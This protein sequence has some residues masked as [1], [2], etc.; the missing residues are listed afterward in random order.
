MSSDDASA[1]AT[2]TDELVALART[3][4]GAALDAVPDGDVLTTLGRTLASEAPSSLRFER[5]ADDLLE[6]G[7]VIG[8]GGMGL[9]RAARQL[10]VGREV[11]VK[12]LRPEQQS[13]VAEAML[14]R[15]AWLTASL[16]HPNVVPVHDVVVDR[17][18][19][20]LI[21]LKRVKGTSW[22]EVLGDGA[23]VKEKFGSDDLLAF[24][25]DVLMQICRAAHFAHASGIVHRDI[26]PS[27]VMLGAYGEVYLLDWGIATRFDAPSA[28]PAIAG[29][30]AYMAPEMLERG[31]RL[32]PRTDVYL[33]GAVLHEI[34]T[35]RAPHHKDTRD[36]II[37]SIL[38]SRPELPEDTPE[39]IARICARALARDPLDRYATA[40]E[41]RLE[42]SH[43]LKNRHSMRLLEE[44]LARL[45]DLTW[46][47]QTRSP[48]QVPKGRLFELFGQCRFGLQQA[49]AS[50]EHNERARR[51]QIDLLDHM[52]RHLLAIEDPG[53]AGALLAEH[54]EP[55]PELAAQVEEG[56]EA[57]RK[58]EEELERLRRDIDPGVGR[59]TRRAAMV[60]MGALWTCAPLLANVVDPTKAPLVINYVSPVVLLLIALGVW[61]YARDKLSQTAINRRF[62]VAMLVGFC[63]HMVHLLV[64]ALADLPHKT[65]LAMGMVSFGAILAILAHTAEKR[66]W[67]LVPVYWLGALV[68]AQDLSTSAYV[69]AGCNLLLTSYMFAIWSPR[70]ER[71]S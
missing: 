31:G 24:N 4:V 62:L 17:D 48:D 35:G 51:A 29:T 58:K 15:E 57:Q 14:L 59:N 22:S 25:L 23:K 40:D 9:V 50:W 49:L 20:P 27:N 44:A 7:E 69:L 64:V 36:A 46:I 19:G 34:V 55:A 6:R 60:A 21:V 2:R 45:G 11:A 66:L 10:S 38:L 18:D 8:E 3:L 32:S 33:L 5:A 53:A 65:E 13:A 52:I 41:L 70:S 63:A 71:R 1:Q 16:E 54:P 30:L 61:Y 47:L 37:A 42:L 56:L 28:T 12:S 26:K 68:G 67:P 43:Y 39:E